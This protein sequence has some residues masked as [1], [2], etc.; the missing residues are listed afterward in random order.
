VE[1]YTVKTSQQLGAVLRGYRKE[2]QLTQQQVGTKSG[3]PQ[4][5]ISRMEDDPGPKALSQLLKV[6]GALD[7]ELAVRKKRTS[8]V[9]ADW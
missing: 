7:L 9:S 8:Q 5:I 6:L 2:R 1:E 4:P 3:V